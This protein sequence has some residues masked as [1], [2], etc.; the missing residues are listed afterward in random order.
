MRVPSLR[1]RSKSSICRSF[2]ASALYLTSNAPYFTPPSRRIAWS[3]DARALFPDIFNASR[4]AFS[5]LRFCAYVIPGFFAL[6]NL[7]IC[8]RAF[9]LFGTASRF[10]RALFVRFCDPIASCVTFSTSTFAR[11]AFAERRGK[12]TRLEVRRRR[13]RFL[14]LQRR[15][16][17]IRRIVVFCVVYVYVYV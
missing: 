7:A 11:F 14:V 15:G 8:L 12:R 17:R 1:F 9:A 10:V 13:R 3:F 5:A 4:A 6:S 16:S 2:F